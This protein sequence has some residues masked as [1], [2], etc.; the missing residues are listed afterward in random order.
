MTEDTSRAV[1]MLIER[2]SL[3]IE[4][5]SDIKDYMY[6]NNIKSFSI[7]MQDLIK[8]GLHAVCKEG[9]GYHGYIDT[10]KF[11]E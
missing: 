10:M 8:K 6:L 7:A 1:E 2:G 3:P 11:I 9:R 5:E 4:L